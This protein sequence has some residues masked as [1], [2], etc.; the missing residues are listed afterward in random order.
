M[1]NLVNIK[2]EAIEGEI[3]AE[4]AL[5]ILKELVVDIESGE[6]CL[7]RF[8]LIGHAPNPTD[9]GEIIPVARAT[10]MTVSEA[11]YTLEC[12]KYRLMKMIHP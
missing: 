5:S 12:E 1:T 3:P 11:V 6:V 4:T 2:G 9:A 8:M 7:E 10:E